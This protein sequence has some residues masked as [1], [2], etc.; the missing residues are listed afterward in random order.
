MFV[1]NCP[2]CSKVAKHCP[3]T[4][5]KTVYP[6]GKLLEKFQRNSK[7]WQK[8]QEHHFSCFFHSFAKK[9]TT[10]T[11]QKKKKNSIFKL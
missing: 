2:N 8:H 1:E 3:K 6:S 5:I 9:I 10:K 4:K 7:K 11:K